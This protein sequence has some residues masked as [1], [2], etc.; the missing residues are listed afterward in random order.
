MRIVCCADSLFVYLGSYIL[1]SVQLWMPDLRVV[2]NSE[3]QFYFRTW[4]MQDKFQSKIKVIYYPSY[5]FHCRSFLFVALRLNAPFET[6]V[7]IYVVLC[8]LILKRSTVIDD[9]VNQQLFTCNNVSMKHMNYNTIIHLIIA[10]GIIT[11]NL[12]ASR[13]RSFSI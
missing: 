1:I 5:Y 9:A 2:R 6:F 10:L 3:N 4:T 11:L 13:F 8:D 7:V 12:N